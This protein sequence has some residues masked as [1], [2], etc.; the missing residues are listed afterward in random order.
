M[1]VFVK[2]G[3]FIGAQIA[4]ME[5]CKNIPFNKYND[6]KVRIYSLFTGY[7]LAAIIYFYLFSFTYYFIYARLIILEIITFLISVVFRRGT[8]C[9]EHE[10]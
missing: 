10:L 7:N 2:F 9:F 4:L 1:F 8:N 5:F 6:N 3:R